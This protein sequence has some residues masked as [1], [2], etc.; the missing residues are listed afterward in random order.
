MLYSNCI[1]KRSLGTAANRP[2]PGTV[3]S[4]KAGCGPDGQTLGPAS[5]ALEDELNDNVV[6]NQP[7]VIRVDYRCF[8]AP[9]SFEH[10][11]VV[12]FSWRGEEFHLFGIMRWHH[13]L[14]VPGG[15]VRAMRG[16]KIRPATFS[17]DPRLEQPTL[18][19]SYDQKAGTNVVFVGFLERLV[20]NGAFLQEEDERIRSLTNT[21]SILRDRISRP[22]RGLVV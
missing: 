3:A 9:R 22:P 6:A 5:S 8:E 20:L 12:V 13:I 16:T 10:R 4:A 19:I 21:H 17:M 18:R 2:S 1:R 11:R 7:A 15:L 14:Q